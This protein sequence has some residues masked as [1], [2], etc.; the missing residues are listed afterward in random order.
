MPRKAKIEAH[1]GASTRRSR[2][3]ISGGSAEAPAAGDDTLLEA[4]QRLVRNGS[5]LEALHPSGTIPVQNGSLT[6]NEDFG[7]HRDVDVSRSY[8]PTY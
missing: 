5:L 8:Q 2:D 7:R 1:R 4:L 3:R 6:K